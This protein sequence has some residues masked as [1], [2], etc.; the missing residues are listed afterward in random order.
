MWYFSSPGWWATDK[1]YRSAY[2]RASVLFYFLEPI[3]WVDLLTRFSL[4][5][6]RTKSEHLFGLLKKIFVSLQLVLVAAWHLDTSPGSTLGPL[7]WEREFYPL[8]TW[9]VPGKH[10]KNW[11]MTSK[12][13]SFKVSNVLKADFMVS[14]AERF[15][16]LEDAWEDNFT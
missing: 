16:H 14:K 2:I 4:S 9:E 12:Y 7:H 1:F 5:W 3:I 15:W 13:Y 11:N 6:N 10:F 8:T